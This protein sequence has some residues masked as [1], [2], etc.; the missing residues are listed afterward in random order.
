MFIKQF[1]LYFH[2]YISE[3]GH[4]NN[5][6]VC[7]KKGGQEHI[8]KSNGQNVIISLKTNVLRRVPDFVIEY[9]GKMR[10]DYCIKGHS[11]NH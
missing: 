8:Y 7:S 10:N 5:V 9:K 4:R 6:T 3:T 1:P 2:S 11:L